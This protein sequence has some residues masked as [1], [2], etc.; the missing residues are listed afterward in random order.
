VPDSS[1]W[2]QGLSIF[3]R[4]ELS[5]YE[6]RVD[7][8]KAF[9]EQ[10]ILK[11]FRVEESSVDAQLFASRDRLTVRHNGLDLR[12]LASGA[13][14]DRALGALDIALE[15]IEPRSPWRLSYSSQYIVGLDLGFEEAVERA[16]GRLMGDLNGSAGG[17][18]GDWSALV[19]LRFE[20][21]P[22]TGQIEFGLI[23][24][25]EAPGRLSRNAGR[26]AGSGQSDEVLW[27]NTEFPGVA[28]FADGRA[29]QDLRQRYE[30]GLAAITRDFW[31]AS[32]VKLGELVEGLHSKLLTED[33]RRVE[34]R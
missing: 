24:G 10:G 17:P 28:L 30:G 5:F 8:L 6:K 34:S 16:Y 7:L 1:P 23:T 4:P 20:D 14:Q 18:F 26:M 3:W 11:A 22:S 32:S 19:D 13:D 29:D 31:N 12:L 25:D 21:F 33:L 2:T 9:E 27:R 15:S